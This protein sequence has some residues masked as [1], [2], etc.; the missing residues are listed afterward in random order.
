MAITTALRRTAVWVCI[1]CLAGQV[2]G[3]IPAAPS[4]ELTDISFPCHVAVGDLNNDGAADLV[5]SSWFPEEDGSYDGSKSRV[6]IYYQ[7]NGTFAA[8]ADKQVVIAN[9]W[10]VSIGDFDADGSNDLAVATKRDDFYLMLGKEKLDVLHHSKDARHRSY[11]VQADRLNDRAVHDFVSGATW[12]KWNGGDQF[13]VGYFYGPEGNNN[14]KATLADLNGDDA[15]DV[16]FTTTDNEVRL[17][18]GPL[19]NKKVVPTDLSQ[20]VQLATPAPPKNVAVG[21]INS[22]GRPDLIVTIRQGEKRQTL[23]YYQQSPTGFAPDAA[24]NV[25]I[26]D[27]SGRPHITDL[28]QDGLDDLVVGDG[29]EHVY[30]FLQKKDAP[31]P[32][33]AE[34]AAQ[35]L[36]IDNYSLAIGDI[37]G[38][39]K[40]DIVAGSVEG[41][42]VR[43]YLNGE[44]T[45]TVAPAPAP[46]PAP[47]VIVKPKT[48]K[49][50]TAG[51]LTDSSAGL[52][53]FQPSI[54][55]FV[56]PFYT[57]TI[58]PVPQKVEYTDRYLSLESTG[59]ILGQDI[60]P[61]DARFR[62]LTERIQRYGGTSRIVDSVSDACDT[63]I[64]LGDTD[65][66]RPTPPD[67]PQGY[68][69]HCT[70]RD[71]KNLVFMRS[72]DH[73]GLLW[74]ITSFNQLVHHR[75]GKIVARAAEVFDYPAILN[76][77]YIGGHWAVVGP[78]GGAWC[79]ARFKMNKF[80]FSSVLGPK[81]P[82]K[83]DWRLEKPEF[84]KQ[85]VREIGEYLTPLGLE[86]YVGDRT[87]SYPDPQQQ[88]RCAS[89]EDFQI[90]LGLADLAARHGGGF[91]LKFD[92]IR[93]PL[94]P[95]DESRFGSAREADVFFVNRLYAAM[96]KNH[97]GSK[98]LFCPVSTGAPLRIIRIR[99]R[100][101]TIYLR[102][103]INCPKKSI[104][105]GPGRA[106]NQTS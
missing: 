77:G 16:I 20:F 99:N 34:N 21:D 4:I 89:D 30:C 94:H 92:D 53:R 102:S 5:V 76:R 66:D 75:D 43:I 36:R 52:D 70:E 91:A 37:N 39:S 38:D 8:P 87:L 69:M 83:Q 24:P 6:Y 46:E 61:D 25:V 54:D 104:S 71:G 98:L 86:W 19:M 35:V 56:V 48:P 93:Y 9:P 11:F 68:V 74:A 59:I 27:V 28:N 31:F 57:G 47:K 17:Y 103:A 106:L 62:V 81:S 58:Q 100:G 2:R 95:E 18:Y 65:L 67:R 12:R 80:V 23:I 29:D 42:V 3:D 50:S 22:D 40:P 105:G 13:D 101:M 44:K 45:T 32:A 51:P 97:P 60:A 49:P 41:N 1:L 33:S 79:T 90:V 10:G 88:I 84:I 85:Q 78:L 26:E 55:P 7:A 15:T 14:K 82:W 63:F 96:Q 72:S 73:Q 64:V